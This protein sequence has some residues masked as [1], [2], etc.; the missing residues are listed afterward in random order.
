[1]YVKCFFR[2]FRA[3]AIPH[4]C[5]PA[6]A[7]FGPPALL[8]TTAALHTSALPYFSPLIEKFAEIF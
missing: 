3:P 4:F 5:P 8:P 1:M 2:I 6:I 7:H